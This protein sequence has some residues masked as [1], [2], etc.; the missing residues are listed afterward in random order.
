MDEA[1]LQDK[2]LRCDTQLLVNLGLYRRIASENNSKF[3]IYT[4]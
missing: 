2:D 3:N 4:I 1:C